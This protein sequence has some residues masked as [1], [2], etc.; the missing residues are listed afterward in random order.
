MANF[1]FNLLHFDSVQF[2]CRRRTENEEHPVRIL[3]GVRSFCSCFIWKVGYTLHLT[4]QD[5][6]S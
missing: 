3:F 1:C 6:S 4:V 2:M 5:Q